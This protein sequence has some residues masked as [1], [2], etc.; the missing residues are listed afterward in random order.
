MS[1]PE[2]KDVDPIREVDVSD[3]KELTILIHH[4]LAA[5]QRSEFGLQI[6]T[7]FSH[8]SLW[9]ASGV[10]IVLVGVPTAAPVVAVSAAVF[11]TM[12]FINKIRFQK[13]WKQVLPQ[14]DRKAEDLTDIVNYYH[15]NNRRCLAMKSCGRISGVVCIKEDSPLLDKRT[16]RISRLFVHPD[17]RRIGVGSRLLQAAKIEAL[18]LGYKM[19]TVETHENNTEMVEF[20]RKKRL[21]EGGSKTTVEMYPLQFNLIAFNTDLVKTKVFS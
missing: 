21:D 6:K 17:C 2:M 7:L 13:F 18:K 16:C 15:H 20:C 9:L 1:R 19:M 11:M 8:Y 10:I 14:F 4:C 12:F 3:K 5:Q